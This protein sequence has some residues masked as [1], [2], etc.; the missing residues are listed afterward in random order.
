MRDVPREKWKLWEVTARVY[1][2]IPISTSLMKKL[3]SREVPVC[4]YVYYYDL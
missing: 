3:E 2:Q 4:M 1:I